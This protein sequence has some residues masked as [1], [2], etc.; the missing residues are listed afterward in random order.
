MDWEPLLAAAAAARAHAYA[1]YSG[2]AVGAAVLAEDGRVFAGCNVEN[3]AFGITLCAERSAVAAAVGA[4]AQVLRAVAVVADADPLATPCGLCRETLTEF[5]ADELPILLA[6]P[7]GR[8]RE[9][10]LGVLLP[11]PFRLP[12]RR[13]PIA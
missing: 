9:T 7:D 13:N 5:G 8:R 11:D 1:P 2:F 3:R 12:R 6:A 10:C 4:G